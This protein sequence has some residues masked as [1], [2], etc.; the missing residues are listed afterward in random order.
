VATCT[1][2][3]DNIFCTIQSRKEDKLCIGTSLSH[4]AHH[5]EAIHLRHHNISNDKVNI[6]LLEYAQ[7]LGAILGN[8]SVVTLDY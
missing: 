3:L 4:P 6:S 1:K 8:E 5:L 2:A 7:S